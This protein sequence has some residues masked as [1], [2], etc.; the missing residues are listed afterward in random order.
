MNKALMIIEN[1]LQQQHV[2][3]LA[4][5]AEGKLWAAN[6]FYLYDPQQIALLVITDL[7]TLHG[8][9]MQKCSQVAGTISQQ[10]IAIN[11][12][13]GI[14]FAGECQL[15]TPNEAESWHHLYQQRLDTAVP[16]TARFWLITLQYMKMVDNRVSFAHKWH[17][18][19]DLSSELP[20]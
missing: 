2:L 11:Q 13:Q 18:Q 9:L 1:Y 6:C 3:S 7:N 15:L 20:S 19:R 17:W 14:Q 8:Q 12:L 5:H 10:Q 4:C 16:P